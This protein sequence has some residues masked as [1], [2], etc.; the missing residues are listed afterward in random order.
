[1][2]A[3]L[4]TIAPDLVERLRDASTSRRRTVMS[5]LVEAALNVTAVQDARVDAG[6]AALRAGSY[7][8][9]V[10]RQELKTL[11]EELDQVGWDTQQRVEQ[12]EA[13]RKVYL[14]AFAR[15]RAVPA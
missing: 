5:A 1:M 15:A 12:G 9:T 2:S 10:E 6:V 4:A 3:R 13:T 8:D 11:E 14:Q 7:G